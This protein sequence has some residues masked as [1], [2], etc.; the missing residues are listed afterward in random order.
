MDQLAAKLEQALK[1][2]GLFYESHLAAW[3]AGR[4]PLEDIRREPQGKLPV[5]KQRAGDSVPQELSG[6]VSQQLDTLEHGAVKWRGQTWNGQP[7]DIAIE[8]DP[9]QGDATDGSGS[10][11]AQRSWRIRLALS[12][13]SLGTVNATVHY[14]GGRASLSLEAPATAQSE[15]QNAS[16]ELVSAL[17]ARGVSAEPVQV[18]SHV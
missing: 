17:A 18:G 6:L 9:D 10:A 7:A 11:P 3:I 2:S 14:A 8:Y 5:S 12:M 4:V 16:G 1:T 15:L 13:P